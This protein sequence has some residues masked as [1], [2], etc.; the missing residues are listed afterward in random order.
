M[1]QQATTLR[2]GN[3][4]PD[5]TFKA[6][7]FK[8]FKYVLTLAKEG[9]FAKAADHLNISQPSLSQYIKKIE[10]QLGILLF[11][12]AGGMVRLTD[13]GRV[14]IEAGRKILDIEHRMQGQLTDLLDHKSGTIVVGTSPYRAASMM[15]SIAKQFQMRH[16]GI[17]LVIEEMPS[18]ELEEATEHGLFDLCLTMLPVNGRLFQYEKIAEEELILAVPGSY[19]LFSSQFLPNRKYS[20]VDA[21]DLNGLPFVTVTEGQFMQQALDNLAIDHKLSFRKVVV[22]KSLEAQISMVRMGVGVALLP[23]GIERFCLQEEVRFYSL[24]QELPKREVIVMWRK[25]CQ[26]NQVTTELLQTMKG[27]C[28]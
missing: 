5:C 6:V 9:S 28:W 22:V 23:S 27:L 24:R 25:G 17:R 16:P 7:N 21:A 14:Y 8:Q 20:A 13:A 4:F 18:Q 12:R 15:P 2:A 1:I 10:T 19:P 11:D 3:C 26:L